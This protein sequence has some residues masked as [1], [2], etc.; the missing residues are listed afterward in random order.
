MRT[1]AAVRTWRI[2]TNS[3]AQISRLVLLTLIHIIAGA[4]VVAYPVARM[5]PAPVRSPIVQAALMAQPRDLLALVHIRADH[6]VRPILKALLAVA[7]VRADRID[8]VRVLLAHLRAVHRTL[9]YILAPL[10][11][12]NHMPRRTDAHIAS[13]LVFARLIRPAQCLAGSTLV[14]VFGGEEAVTIAWHLQ[15]N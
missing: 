8:A 13:L 5:A 15:F 9:I 3:H 11:P 6:L 14:D 1:P 4:I 12:T 10:V 2:L 7:P